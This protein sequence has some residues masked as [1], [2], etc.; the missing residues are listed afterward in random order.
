MKISK[1][2]NLNLNLKLV[3]TLVSLTLMLSSLSILSSQSIY[4]Q[5]SE[6][7]K[8][9]NCKDNKDQ[10]QYVSN[11]SLVNGTVGVGPVTDDL[12]GFHYVK[13]FDSNGT[14]IT[15]WGIK[16]TGPGQFLHV[17]GIA[18]DSNGFVYVSDAEKCNI[19]KFDSEGNFIKAWDIKV[20]DKD[21]SCNL[22][23]WQ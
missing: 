2:E 16:G 12:P 6:D 13:K 4:S 19:Q 15:A 7:P 14:L 8:S 21:N 9:L 3:V 10:S 17:H 18:V 11:V 22:R 20:R 5:T 23:A 1:L